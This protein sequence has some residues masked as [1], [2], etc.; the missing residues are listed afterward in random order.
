LVSEILK[1]FFFQLFV[2][3]LLIANLLVAKIGAIY[4]N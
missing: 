4:Y 1:R 2:I 3:Q